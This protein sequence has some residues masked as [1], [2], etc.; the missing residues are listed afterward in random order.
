[1]TATG[2]QTADQIVEDEVRELVRRRGLDPGNGDA[3]AVRQLID[4]VVTDHADRRLVASS[5]PTAS[6]RTRA[7]RG[8]PVTSVTRCC[9]RTPGAPGW[10]RNAATHRARLTAPW[11]T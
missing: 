6:S 5:S 11:R 1:M 8:W 4:E 3:V 10:P 2:Q 9:V 7:I